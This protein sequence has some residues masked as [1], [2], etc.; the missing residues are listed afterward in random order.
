MPTGLLTPLSSLI[1][2]GEGEPL[3]RNNGMTRRAAQ[4]CSVGWTRY[5]PPA[6]TRRH[7]PSIGRLT[8]GTKMAG[9]VPRPGEAAGTEADKIDRSPF[10]GG[11]YAA[12]ALTLP[13]ALGPKG[14]SATR[15]APRG[16]GLCPRHVPPR[17]FPH[18][19]Q[20]VSTRY[21]LQPGC[22]LAVWE[23]GSGPADSEE[24]DRYG[25][26]GWWE[27]EKGGRSRLPSQ[28]VGEPYEANRRTHLANTIY[29][30]REGN[31]SAS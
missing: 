19:P 15:S 27:Y 28:E 8:L 11:C 26:T 25:W 2:A 14:L 5:H 22:I 17:S 18:R 31:A 13:V 4:Q 16:P 7:S 23:A 10:I 12:R 24:G 21:L 9:R 6:P 3:G 20:H 30:G 1:H 29:T